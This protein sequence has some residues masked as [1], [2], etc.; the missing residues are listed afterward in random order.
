MMTTAM[1]TIPAVQ[2]IANG[3]SSNV[4]NPLNVKVVD[5]SSIKE[6]SKSSTGKHVVTLITGDVVT[7]TDLADGKSVI[8]VEPANRAGSGA[9]ILKVDKDTYVIP[10]EAMPYLAS[11]LLDRDL[12]NIT[13]LIADGYDD[14]K[15]ST[16]PVIVQYAATKGRSLEV[17]PATPDGSKRTHV[18]E[19]IGAAAV[20][21]DK[22]QVKS[23]WNDIAQ[24][25]TDVKGI[26]P[27]AAFSQGETVQLKDGIEKIWLDGRVKANLEQ[28]VPQ[29]EA[30]KAWDA[31][32]DG[33]DVKVAVLDTG[34]DTEHPDVADQLD[35]AMSFVPGEDA[36]DHHAHGTHVAST[37]LGTG[38]ASEGLNKG[39]APGARLL[40]GKVLDNEG[41][42]QDFWII[43]GMEWAANNAK[44][45]S[46]SLGNSEPSDGTDPMAQAVNRLS[47]ETGALFVIA[48]GNTGAEGI[49]SLYA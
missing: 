15:R 27:M 21:A 5:T 32:Y 48:A 25:S 17:L 23:F 10:N 4:E 41:Y 3:S 2:A 30:P 8:N 7:V 35:K 19:S 49:G 29:V 37:V 33:K 1:L 34:I 42:G 11:G 24:T 18:L 39:V 6:R 22:E 14:G 47:E 38:A 16:L 40:V 26:S 12:F 36:L 43:D 28:S 45:V 46:M 13:A 31:G 9:R 20:S 44:V